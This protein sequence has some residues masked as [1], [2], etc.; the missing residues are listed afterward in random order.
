MKIVAGRWSNW[1]GSVA[2]KPRTVIAPKDEV[3]LAA[4][5]RS[6]EGMV[7]VPGLGHSFTPLCA[8]DDTLIDMAAFRGLIC[9]DKAGATATFKSATGLW[10]TGPALYAHNL[11]LI[12][13]GDVD[14]QTFAGA[15]GTGTH[16]TGPKFRSLSGEIAGFRLILADGS[17]LACSRN[18]NSEIFEAGRLGLGLLGVMTEIT[19]NVRSAYRLVENSF[20]LPPKELFRKL[21]YLIAANRHFEFFWF[22]YADAVVCKTLNESSEPATGPR[23]AEQMRTRGERMTI[24]LRIFS[25]LNRVLPFAP[26]LLKPT[27]RLFSQSM[28]PRPMPHWSHEA[29]PSA[30]PIRF[31]EMEY[32]VPIASGGDCVNEIVAMIR[33]RKIATGFPLQFRSVAADDVWISPFQGRDTATIAVRQH[34]RTDYR[35]LFRACEGVFQAYGGR[36]HWGKHH[37]RT[38]AELSAL[39]PRYDAF[40]ALRRRL[41]PAGKFLNPYLK[42]LFD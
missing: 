1:S 17:V 6:A 38:K 12:N 3:E 30:R 5:V 22:P 18:Q 31:N 19:T 37:F 23:T 32:A 4:A 33:K 20:L 40:L 26:F 13:M 27:H 14:R 16:G 42:Q 35:P 36:P 25:A 41:D 39:Y 34:Y 2:C 24:D 15:I 11:G 21:D 9:A 29:F 7:R 28:S 8:S 10:E